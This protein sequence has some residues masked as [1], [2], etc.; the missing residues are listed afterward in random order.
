[1]EKVLDYLKKI[2]NVQTVLDSFSDGRIIQKVL[3]TIFQALAVIGGV[4]FIYIWFKLWPFINDLNFTGGL[5]YLIW[6][7]GIFYA[8]V[9]ALRL[10]YK[11]SEEM[12]TYPDSDY[13]VVPVIAGVVRAYGEMVFTI[14][15]ILSVP[16]MLLVWLGGGWVIDK[17]SVIDVGNVFLSGLV[18]FIITWIWGFLFLLVTRFIAEITLAIFSIANDTKKIREHTLK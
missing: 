16:A 1:M 8:V 11:R 10:F 3:G 7:F 5:G 6:Q 12:K 18:A 17:I 15:G 14:A 2:F 13:V 9:F 4:V